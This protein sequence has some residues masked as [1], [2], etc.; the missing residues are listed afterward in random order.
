MQLTNWY[1]R[2]LN[3]SDVST[4]ISLGLIKLPFDDSPVMYNVD[5]DEICTFILSFL[6][7][8][9]NL[10]FGNIEIRRFVTKCAIVDVPRAILTSISSL[11]VER[12]ERNFLRAIS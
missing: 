4:G 3:F 12:K 7:C 6:R 2:I 9:K 5:I 8:K 10:D 11:F 1:L